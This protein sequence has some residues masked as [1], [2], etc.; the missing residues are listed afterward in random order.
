MNENLATIQK[1][2]EVNIHPNADALS[3]AKVLGWNVIIK[4]DEY[5][6]GDLACYVCIDT[7]LP[8][9]AEF[10]F[11]RNKHFRI[12]P[13]RLR[14]EPSNGILFP[15]SIL[16]PREN[17]YQ[18]DE[19]VTD[20]V[21]VIK[22]ERP[23]PAQLMGDAHG[24]I[25]GW[26]II[27]DELSLRS[28]P[29]ALVEMYGR[30]YYTTVKYDGSSGNFFIKDNEFGVCSRRIHLKE[31]EGNSFWKMA[32]KYNV[33]NALR[34]A[35]PN[36]DISINA[37]VYGPGIQK[38]PL[39]ITEID[40][41]LYNLFDIKHRVYLGYDALVK[42]SNEAGI[43][44]VKVIDEGIMFGHNLEDLI[45]L[46]NEQKYP[47]GK[48]AEGI[49]VRSKD[50]FYSTVLKKTWSGKIISELYKEQD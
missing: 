1:I 30:P 43:P 49:V 25:P 48:P 13:I 35:F 7:V 39:G 27:S 3:I 38:N 26:L 9:K 46:S 10:E 18:E 42:F 6:I 44:M 50:P 2:Q 11:L 19:D 29:D 4:K 24:T 15:L 47:N 37:E 36:I 5:K 32:K 34:T 20:L 33:E 31:S 12:Q 41:A 45:K 23:M 22:Y 17:P 21:G 40:M 28:Y 16:P 14:K 8:E